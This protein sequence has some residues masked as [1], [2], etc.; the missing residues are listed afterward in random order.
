[1]NPFTEFIGALAECTRCKRLCALAGPPTP[2]A[3]LLR[4]ATADHVAEFGGLCVDC[5]TT[6]FLKA[7]E[8]VPATIERH[9][10]A[11]LLNPHVQK[12]FITLMISGKA[13]ARP[14][15]I[16]WQ[17]VVDNWDLPFPKK[18]RARQK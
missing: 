8:I 2:E 17:N 14:D 13:D 7:I 11:M 15:E 1:M 12:Q 16:N 3:R 18:K 5:A 9:G 4:F 6:G 10:V